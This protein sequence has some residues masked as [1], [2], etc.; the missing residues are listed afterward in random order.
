MEYDVVMLRHDGGG[1]STESSPVVLWLK[2]ISRIRMHIAY[3]KVAC[4]PEP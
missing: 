2:D 3:C 4:F 1:L